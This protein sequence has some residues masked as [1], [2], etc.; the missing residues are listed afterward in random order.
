MSRSWWSI[1]SL[2]SRVHCFIGHDD[3]GTLFVQDRGSLNGV[4]IGGQKV[5]VSNLKSD[6]VLFLGERGL[7]RVE[8]EKLAQAAAAA[9]PEASLSAGK[10]KVALPSSETAGTIVAAGD[11]RPPLA[12]K[13][14]A[15]FSVVR[16]AKDST[17]IGRSH[18]NDVVL[19]HPLVSRFHAK[20]TREGAR[21][22][23]S[24]LKSGNGTYVSGRR[25]AQAVLNEGDR[26]SV[27]P[28]SYTLGPGHVLEGADLQDRITVLTDHLV[29][30]VK[31]RAGGGEKTLLD[32][33]SIVAH[34]SE[35]IG[36][37]G[38]SGC[39]KTAVRAGSEQE[40]CLRLYRHDLH[41]PENARGAFAVD[42]F[43]QKRP[44]L[45]GGR[46]EH[47]GTETKW[48]HRV[49][50]IC[51]RHGDSARVRIRDLPWRSQY[52]DAVI[53]IRRADHHIPRRDVRAAIQRKDGGQAKCRRLRGTR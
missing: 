42:F 53:P 27:G 19:D 2:I 40:V 13:G 17:T 3:R 11:F 49:S 46:A 22:V 10:V 44:G 33:I 24:D 31:D 8:I 6:T 32:D 50:V 47:Q 4:F 16:I 28:F 30:K 37:V 15:P 36:I 35:L 7:V 20:I 21:L 51:S 12:A 9:L 52:F 1:V 29:K 14:A 38:P 18:H 45:H 5:N 23:L 39:G 43:Q 48:K 26:V 25:I 41:S 34:Q